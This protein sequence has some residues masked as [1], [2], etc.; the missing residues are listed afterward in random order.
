M[1]IHSS[2]LGC[3]RDHLCMGIGVFV[4]PIIFYKILFIVYLECHNIYIRF[5]SLLIYADYVQTSVGVE[6][7]FVRKCF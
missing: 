6:P 7:L 4:H 5:S 3:T 1:K 2:Y